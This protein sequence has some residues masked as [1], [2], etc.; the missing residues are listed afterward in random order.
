MNFSPTLDAGAH[1]QPRRKLPIGIQILDKLREQNC[2]CVDKNALALQLIESGNYCFLRRPRRF[3]N[4]QFLDILCEMF[5][6]KQALFKGLAA[7][8]AWD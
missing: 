7:E 6:G 1:S 4:S 3:G 2:Y 5:K 8:N